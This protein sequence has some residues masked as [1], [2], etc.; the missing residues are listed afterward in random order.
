MFTSIRDRGTRDK[1]PYDALLV[2]PDVET[3]MN[4]SSELELRSGLLRPLLTLVLVGM[5]LWFAFVLVFSSTNDG[6]FYSIAQPVPIQI[7]DSRHARLQFDRTSARSMAGICCNELQCDTVQDFVCTGCPIE[8]GRSVFQVS[9]PIIPEA[10]NGP[11]GEVMCRYT[12]TVQY[13]PLGPLGP[14][15]THS[16]SSEYFRVKRDDYQ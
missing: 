11:G 13:K 4:V 2:E 7:T 8:A 1:N 16:W 12:G 9:L 15:M 14:H 5:S 3:C 10:I 6:L